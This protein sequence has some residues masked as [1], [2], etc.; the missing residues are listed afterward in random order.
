MKYLIWLK[1][2]VIL[3]LSIFFFFDE[4]P[5][6]DMTDWNIIHIF[7]FLFCLLSIVYE[8]ILKSRYGQFVFK[9]QVL[10]FSIF[11]YWTFLQ[12]YMLLV[13]IIFCFHCLTPLEVELFELIEIY[14]NLFNLFFFSII[15]ILFNVFILFFFILLIN[16]LIN[17]NNKKC[18]F[19]IFYIFFLVLILVLI[20]LL[21]DFLFSSLTSVLFW[22]NFKIFYIQSK[23]SLTYNNLLYINDQFDWHKEQTNFFIIRFEDLYSYFILLAFVIIFVYFLYIIYF[24][25]NDVNSYYF[26]NKDIS[27][28]SFSIIFTLLNNF[29]YIFY[30]NYLLIFLVGLRVSFKILIENWDYFFFF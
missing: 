3:Y 27:Y 13:V 29:S 20:F 23:S 15:F 14:N 9:D 5:F 26:Y 21:W 18:I 1:F 6:F 4:E 24:I 8:N 2:Y 25:F 30:V 16:F 28:L 22:Y 17:W 12:N 19:I 11:S 7:F 10:L